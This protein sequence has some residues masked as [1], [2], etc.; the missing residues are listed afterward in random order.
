MISEREI[1]Q[2]SQP[3]GRLQ[4]PQQSD[5]VTD[6]TFGR[7]VH[8]RRRAGPCRVTIFEGGHEGIVTAGM[9]WLKSHE[10]P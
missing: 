10:K 2:I 9:A 1:Q 7:E 5:Q 3:D 6:E 4:S 8:L